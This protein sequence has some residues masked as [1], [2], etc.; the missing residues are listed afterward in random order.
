MA[1]K[2]TFSKL[3]LKELKKEIAQKRKEQLKNYWK[4]ILHPL[5]DWGQELNKDLNLQKDA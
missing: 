5:L 3:E 2:I 4:V 1:K